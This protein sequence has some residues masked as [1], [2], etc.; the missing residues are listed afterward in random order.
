MEL[1]RSI[2]FVIVCSMGCTR[3][4][5]QVNCLAVLSSQEGPLTFAVSHSNPRAYRIRDPPEDIT[6]VRRMCEY[7]FGFHRRISTNPQLT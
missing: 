2:K 5:G 1:C 6:F 7:K 3:A 4:P